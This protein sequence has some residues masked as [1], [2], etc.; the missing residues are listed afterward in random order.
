MPRGVVFRMRGAIVP[1]QGSEE[2][3][4]TDLGFEC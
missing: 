3:G 2:G 4:A 1:L